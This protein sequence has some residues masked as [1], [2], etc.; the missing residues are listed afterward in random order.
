[1]SGVFARV[2]SH[3][4]EKVLVPGINVREVEDYFINELL[5]RIE[6]SKVHRRAGIIDTD[7]LAERRFK[8]VHAVQPES[9]RRRTLKSGLRNGEKNVRGK[10]IV[11]AQLGTRLVPHSRRRILEHRR[12]S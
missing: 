4:M 12:F 9:A 7:L 5:E 6:R 3:L 11:H 2:A 10:I 1:L 8:I